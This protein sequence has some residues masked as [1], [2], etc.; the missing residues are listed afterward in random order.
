MKAGTKRGKKRTSRLKNTGNTLNTALIA[1]DCERAVPCSPRKATNR[2]K[3][4]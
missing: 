4:L 1:S 2:A 3:D